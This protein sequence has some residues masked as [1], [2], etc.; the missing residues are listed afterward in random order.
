[1]LI[2]LLEKN[3][4][5]IYDDYNYKQNNTRI[6]VE[7]ACGRLKGVWKI[8]HCPIWN[9]NEKLVPNLIYVC[10]LSHNIIL[11]YNDIVDDDVPLVGHHDE[12]RRQ[13]ISRQ[14]VSSEAKE[15]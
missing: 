7:Q 6:V 10:C 8:L 12:G 2:P 11:E 15:I 14:V 13:Q 3:L 5:G 1:M 9:H 4:S